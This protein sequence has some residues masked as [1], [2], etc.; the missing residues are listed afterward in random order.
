MHSAVRVAGRRLYDYAR[1]GEVVP[2]PAR[3]IEILALKEIQ[4]TGNEL[5]VAVTCS[6]GTYIRTLAQDIGAALGCGAHLVGLRRTVVG[7]FDVTSAVSFAAL[8]AAGLQGAKGFLLA[9]ESL[10]IGL[11]RFEAN[12]D[13]AERFAHGR[14]IEACAGNAG[15]EVAVYGPGGRFLGVGSRNCGEGI[16]PLRLMSP[17]RAKYPDFA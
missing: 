3:R 8:E 11:T 14:A 16:A 5:T 10:V 9:P 7:P 13:E 4:R 17:T 12:A 1:A 2:R 15:S 6:K